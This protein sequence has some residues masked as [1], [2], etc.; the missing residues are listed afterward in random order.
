MLTQ[1]YLQEIFHY[2]PETGEL[3]RKKSISGTNLKAGQRAGAMRSDG[4][5]A[6]K[7]DGIRYLEHRVIWM[8][9]F[10]DWPTQ[11]IDHI[12][13]IIDDNRISNLRDVC[14]SHN[15]QNQRKPRKDNTSG[16]LGVTWS[17]K[18]QSWI[19]QIGIN[20]T[21]K[22]IG[23]YKTAEQAHEAY[24]ITKRKMHPGGTI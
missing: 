13:G 7:I 18:L 23:V 9:V 15:Q 8:Y 22:H 3:I 11:D 12:N 19:A 5:R 21:R 20:G 14:K 6:V 4:Y 17:V 10:G 1:S 2:L 16:Y 24:L